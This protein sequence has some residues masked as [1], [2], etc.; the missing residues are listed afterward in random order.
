[1][2]MD[3]KSSSHAFPYNDITGKNGSLNY[4]AT[5]SKIDDDQLFYLQSRGL[6]EDDAKLLIIN[7]FCEGVTKH[8][9]VEYSVEMTRLIRMILEDGHV[10]EEV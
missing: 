1:M 3:E 10:I 8:L 5:V 9:N 6:S 2:N 7:G 4:E